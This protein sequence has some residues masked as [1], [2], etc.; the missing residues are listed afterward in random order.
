MPSEATK[1]VHSL[2]SA[3]QG[4]SL[5]ISYLMA[6]LLLV[7]LFEGDPVRDFDQTSYCDW[8]PLRALDQ[9]SDCN[10][11]PPREFDEISDRDWDSLRVFD[12]ASNCESSLFF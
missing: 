3:D 11:D 12:Q 8:D 10:W 7:V 4:L 6:V 9:E 2:L 1:G 5:N